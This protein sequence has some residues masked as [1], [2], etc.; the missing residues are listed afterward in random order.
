MYS[1]AYVWGKVL[2]YIEERLG[3][4]IVSALLDD[5]EVVE[6]SD[7]NLI[8]YSPTEKVPAMP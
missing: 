7:S 4:T 5:A 3:P 6:L 1:S 2:G 8:L